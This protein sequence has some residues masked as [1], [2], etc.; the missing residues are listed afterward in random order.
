[1]CSKRIFHQ[2][3]RKNKFVKEDHNY[4]KRKKRESSGKRAVLKERHKNATPKKKKTIENCQTSRE[5]R[6]K[7]TLGGPGRPPQPE[8]ACKIGARRVNFSG[9]AQQKLRFGIFFVFF[10]VF[11][12]SKFQFFFEKWRLLISIIISSQYNVTV[13]WYHRANADIMYCSQGCPRQHWV[14]HHCWL[15]HM[16]QKTSHGIT[17]ITII[18]I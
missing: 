5:Y 2:K 3:N 18:T 1:M 8:F 12:L 7:Y 9:S 16:P 15:M 4:A 13:L 14:G 11:F 6:P 10:P 17:I